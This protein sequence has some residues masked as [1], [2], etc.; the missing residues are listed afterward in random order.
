MGNHTVAERMYRHNPGIILS[1][2]L[3][4]TIYEDHDDRLWFTVD[5][6]STHF[7]S[8]SDPEIASVGLE[9]D[10]SSP[11]CSPR[12]GSPFPPS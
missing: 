5:Q 6:P 11:T 3:R 9:L 4:T 12:P 7:S 1:A 2:P 8:F 10:E